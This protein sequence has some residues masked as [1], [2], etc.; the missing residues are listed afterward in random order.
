MW[1]R[2]AKREILS[3][4]QL[5]LSLVLFCL[6]LFAKFYGSVYIL[7]SVWQLVSALVYMF[8]QVTRGRSKIGDRW[9]D[10]WLTGEVS[11]AVLFFIL[12]LAHLFVMV[13]RKLEKGRHGGY[14]RITR[15][16]YHRWWRILSPH[17]SNVTLS[18]LEKVYAFGIWLYLT[19]WVGATSTWE[20]IGNCWH[21]QI[22][23]ACSSL[24]NSFS[25]N[26]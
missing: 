9:L 25:W 26:F 19:G 18:S 20:H 13:C 23:W 4:L 16:Q 11:W 21:L 14:F 22:Q 17:T 3:T 2:M 10:P 12:F 7:W 5:H 24:H 6:S 15:V 1:K 8:N